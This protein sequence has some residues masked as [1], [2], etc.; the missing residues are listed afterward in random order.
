MTLGR[1]TRRALA[2]AWAGPNS[3]LGLAAGLAVLALG[4]RVQRHSGALEFHGGL[5]ARLVSALPGRLRFGALTL[6]HVIL[7]VDTA[8]LAALRAHEQVHVRQYERWG[9]FFLP[10]YAASS[11]WQLLR[12]R[13]PH[14]DNAFERQARALEHGPGRGTA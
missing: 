1:R 9:P 10:A 13:R 4:G 11:A 7:G 3:V 2:L 6:G 8:Q 12:G 5:G 14:T